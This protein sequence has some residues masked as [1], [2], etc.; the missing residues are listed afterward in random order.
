MRSLPDGL[1]RSQHLLASVSCHS[2]AM[3]ALPLSLGH[4]TSLT[5]LDASCNRINALPAQ[6]LLAGGLSVSLAEL[7]LSG[8]ALRALPQVRRDAAWCPYMPRGI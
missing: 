3:E 2:N 4:S 1:G 6:M 7:N 5:K 8:N